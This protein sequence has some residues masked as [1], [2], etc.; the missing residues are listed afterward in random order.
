MEVTFTQTMDMSEVICYH[1]GKKGHYAKTCPKKESKKAQVHTQMTK[2]EFEENDVEDELGY[3][4][5]QR[6]SGL[7]WKT[8]LLIDS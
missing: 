5:H 6:L 2:T 1:Y 4:Y 7:N 8:C 3:I